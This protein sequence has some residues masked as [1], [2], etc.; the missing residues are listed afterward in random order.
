MKKVRISGWWT[1]IYA[2]ILLVSAMLVFAVSIGAN[3]IKYWG[4]SV[5]IDKGSDYQLFRVDDRHALYV[6][7]NSQEVS[8]VKYEK[9]KFF[10]FL[11]RYSYDAEVFPQV[12]RKGDWLYTNNAGFTH[13]GRPVAL[14]YKT[15]KMMMKDE[16]IKEVLGYTPANMA[17]EGLLSDGRYQLS[18]HQLEQF[19]ELDVPQESSIILTSA[20]VAIHIFW[21]FM[22]PF[23]VKKVK[24]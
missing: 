14:N 19:P 4:S 17:A 11:G 5:F 13:P 22:L 24:I 15:G 16:A 12:C 9:E 8:L 7:P 2:I 23:A 10:R 18:P 21:L 3:G 6:L 20:L 1:S